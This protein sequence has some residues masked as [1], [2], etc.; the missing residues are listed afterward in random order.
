MT[1]SHFPMPSNQPDTSPAHVPQEMYHW[2]LY[3]TPVAYD[4]WFQAVYQHKDRPLW[5]A[6]RPTGDGDDHEAAIFADEGTVDEKPLTDA[7]CLLN[8]LTTGNSVLDGCRVTLDAGVEGAEG[9][10][11][12]YAELE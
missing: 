1:V 4:R 12:E 10:A 3:D 9:D 2:T 11:Y 7:Q 6:I 8:I 5:L